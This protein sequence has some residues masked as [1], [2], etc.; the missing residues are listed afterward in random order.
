[1]QL[2][3]LWTTPYQD[4]YGRRTLKG[5]KYLQNIIQTLDS[6]RKLLLLVGNQHS[7]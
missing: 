6:L 5:P 3:A 7:P 2:F 4:I 1:M